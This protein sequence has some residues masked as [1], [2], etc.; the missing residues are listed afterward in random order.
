M[1]LAG[2][3]F[4]GPTG[5][6]SNHASLPFTS[7]ITLSLS[8]LF[9]DSLF[10]PLF[11]TGRPPLSSTITSFTTAAA[12]TSFSCPCKPPNHFPDLPF[13]HISISPS[14]YV[15]PAATIIHPTIS[16]IYHSYTQK[17]RTFLDCFVNLH[18][19]PPSSAAS[20]HHKRGAL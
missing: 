9:L 5:L 15:Y 20:N 6:H 13:L 8:I 7:Y 1:R 11:P 2:R 3:H 14:F 18:Q 12:V 10:C 17:N 4:V 16:Q 19:P